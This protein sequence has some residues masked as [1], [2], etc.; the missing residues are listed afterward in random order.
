MILTFF[1]CYGETYGD[2]DCQSDTPLCINIFLM[3]QDEKVAGIELA[4]LWLT[5]NILNVK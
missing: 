2:R 3:V 1:F 4:I 5:Q